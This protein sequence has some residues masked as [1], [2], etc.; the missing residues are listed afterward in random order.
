MGLPNCGW[1]Q[2]DIENRP[3]QTKYRGPLFILAIK[4]EPILDDIEDAEQ[5][6][7]ELGITI[8]L[9]ETFEIGGIV[10][11]VDLVDC[12]TYSRSPWFGY[13]MVSSW[14]TTPG[15]LYPIVASNVCSQLTAMI[16]CSISFH[17]PSPLSG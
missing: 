12:V 17:P 5:E 3:W 4:R 6:C 15:A 10:G 8:S 11:I 16:I 9:P 2:K 13:C 1:L 7:K 14:P